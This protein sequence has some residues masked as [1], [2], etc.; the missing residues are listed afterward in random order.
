M[1]PIYNP[2]AEMAALG[3]MLLSPRAAAE[4]L[5]T[6][7]GF[8]FYRPS[9]RTIFEAMASLL[10]EKQPVD[11]VTL[12]DALARDGQ[13][14]DVGGYDFLLDLSLQDGTP[15]NAEGYFRIVRRDS[16]RREAIESAKRIVRL[17]NEDAE[18]ES[19]LAESSAIGERFT[20]T[21]ARIPEVSLAS[22]LD[23]MLYGKRPKGHRTG[24][25]MIDTDICEQRG[26][27]AAG[28]Y[29]LISAPSGK[30]KSTFML[31]VMLPALRRGEPC[32]FGTF[33]DLN[34]VDLMY[35]AVRFANPLGL[36]RLDEARGEEERRS[37]LDAA[38]EVAGWPWG[39]YDA[40]G[41]DGA[42]TI[43]VFRHWLDKWSSRHGAPTRVGMDYAQVIVTNDS[44]YLGNPTMVN[45]RVSH[46]VRMMAS[47]YEAAF[48]MGSQVT[49]KE[50]GSYNTKHATDWF[51]HAAME[52]QA[53]RG[54]LKITKNR[55]GIDECEVPTVWDPRHLMVREAAE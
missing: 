11:I 40:S 12:K 26:G 7:K 45:Q 27:M 2:D 39:L 42:N 44:R 46:I 41:S 15:T 18:P 34:D 9:H 55:H 29:T 10:S 32:V 54:A 14:G 1:S 47:D 43:E 20:S 49:K 19:I 52:I 25:P 33:A 48:M 23:R 24:F 8:D 6:L 4:G 35:R 53:H 17:A 22:A 37:V 51:D 13:L 36:G 50:D 5:T 30:G 3:V 28:Q 31:S 16:N 21:G 38:E